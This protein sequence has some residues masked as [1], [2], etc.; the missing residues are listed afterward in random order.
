[1]IQKANSHIFLLPEY[2]RAALGAARAGH[3]EVVDYLLYNLEH[4]PEG[5]FNQANREVRLR[6]AAQIRER[7]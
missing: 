5:E 6:I 3:S 4:P 7:L 1:M 2:A